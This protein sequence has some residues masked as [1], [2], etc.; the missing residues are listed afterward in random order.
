M[1]KQYRFSSIKLK[2]Y[3]NKIPIQ[4]TN[5]IGKYD[6]KILYGINQPYSITHNQSEL[7]PMAELFN[8]IYTASTLSNIPIG[9]N[10]HL[11]QKRYQITPLESLLKINNDLNILYNFEKSTELS[12]YNVLYYYNMEVEV[13]LETPSGIYKPKE[14]DLIFINNNYKHLIK[15]NTG[16]FDILQFKFY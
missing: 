11:L 7:Y 8:Y 1:L 2:N 16:T 12:K 4:N 14:Y 15:K 9:P 10:F 6:S 5:M 3:L 13:M